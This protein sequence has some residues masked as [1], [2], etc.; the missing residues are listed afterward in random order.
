M[1]C[2]LADTGCLKQ[3]KTQGKKVEIVDE[4]ELDTLRCTAT[5]AECLKRAKSAGKK[6]EIID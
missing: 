5:D 3:A 2:V 6:V 4:A 1:K